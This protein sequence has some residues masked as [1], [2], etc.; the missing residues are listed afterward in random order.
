MLS[1][2]AGL[3]EWLVLLN[4]TWGAGAS[5]AAGIVLE[6]LKIESKP[7]QMRLDN[8]PMGIRRGGK[9]PMKDL[10]KAADGSVEG[11]KQ[12]L[13]QEWEL[14]ED[15]R[16]AVYGVDC[17]GAEFEFTPMVAHD[18]TGTLAGAQAVLLRVMPLQHVVSAHT[19]VPSLST[20][21]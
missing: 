1:E 12:L 7:I 10:V 8:A 9:L 20:S 14:P 11:L 21:E 5:V 13:K 6:K 2:G 15:T 17:D 18:L 19:H 3:P 4:L 16:V